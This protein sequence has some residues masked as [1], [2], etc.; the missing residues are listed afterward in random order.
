MYLPEH[1]QYVL[2]RLTGAGYAAFAVGGCV[3]DALAGR[4]PND[5]DV[6]SSARPEQVHAVFAGQNVRDTG[7]QHGTVTVVLGHEP[8][9]ITTFRVDGSYSDSRH[10]DHVLFTDDIRSDL[11]RRDFTINAM[12]YHPEQGLIDPFGGQADMNSGLIRCVGNPRDRFAEDALRI[13]RALRFAARFGYR[14]E[15]ETDA[16]LHAL[17]PSLSG[18]AAERVRVELDGILLA[19]DAGHILLAYSDVLGVVLPEALPC[20][21]FN[22]RNPH[23]RYDVWEHTIHAVDAAPPDAILRWTMLFHDLGKPQTFSTDSQGIGHFY[24]HAHVSAALADDIMRRLRFSNA[25]RECIEELVRR[26]D[27]VIPPDK[28]ALR[29]LLSRIGRAQFDRLLAVHRADNMAQAPELI[30]PRLRELSV[31]SA[32]ADEIEREGNCTDTRHLAVNG[33]DLL[34]LGYAPGPALG[35]EM[36]LLLDRVL[37]QPELNEKNTLLRLAKEDLSIK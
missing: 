6:C 26:H 22:Q 17:A 20:V 1:I 29:R 11:A 25:E 31:I 32:L 34:A 35:A 12:A 13:L 4:T 23:H 3:R 8:V 10:P 33:H 18:I 24:R 7:L 5:Y 28:K 21:G 2:S 27:G 16:A 14:M 36:K 37:E 15:P 30:E 19:P 9:E